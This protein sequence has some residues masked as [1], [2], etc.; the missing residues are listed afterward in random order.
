MAKSTHQGVMEKLKA[1]LK[2]SLMVKIV[3][4]GIIVEWADMWAGLLLVGCIR[5]TVEQG[6]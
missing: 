5:K 4:L 6:P 1:T 3:N 2:S